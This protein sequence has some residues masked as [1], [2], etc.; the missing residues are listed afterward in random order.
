MV[1]AKDE[2]HTIVLRGITTGQVF[3]NMYS[4]TAK[5][6]QCVLQNQGQPKKKFNHF[7]TPELPMQFICMELVGP[8][9]PPSSKGNKY[10]LTIIDM[11]TGFTIAPPIPN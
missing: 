9:H 1:I 3:T 7:D 2:R 6:A 5:N 11:L 10:I 4:D 8:I